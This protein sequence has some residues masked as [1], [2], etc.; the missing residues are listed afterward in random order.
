MD[1]IVKPG[2]KPAFAGIYEEVS[3]KEINNCCYIN[4]NDSILPPTKTPDGYWRWT[5]KRQKD[6]A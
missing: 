5:G 1:Y 4:D 3:N 6:K 2:E